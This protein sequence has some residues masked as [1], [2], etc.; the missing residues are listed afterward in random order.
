MLRSS[1]SYY[2]HVFRRIAAI[3]S[4]IRT[5]LNATGTGLGRNKLRPCLKCVCLLGLCASTLFTECSQSISVSISTIKYIASARAYRRM[6]WTDDFGQHIV[7]YIFLTIC[8][9]SVAPFYL[10]CICHSFFVLSH[11]S[12]FAENTMKNNYKWGLDELNI[13]KWLH[14]FTVSCNS[15]YF[16]FEHIKWNVNR[17]TR[18]SC[19]CL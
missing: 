9:I 5:V 10:V 3:H 15:F 1:T 4:F 16:L 18:S 7:L 17:G 6:R 8:D 19:S 14:C 11:I 12:P 2:S 13:C